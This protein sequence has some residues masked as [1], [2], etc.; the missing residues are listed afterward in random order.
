MSRLH[1]TPS[2]ARMA[3]VFALALAAIAVGACGSDDGSGGGKEVKVG[4]VDEGCDPKNLSVPAGP[5]T[6]KIT[7]TG[8]DKIIEMEVL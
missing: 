1:V 2:Y 6:F 3:T 7:N 4:L 5:T 8:T